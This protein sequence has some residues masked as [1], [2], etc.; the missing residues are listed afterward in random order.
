MTKRH[1][2]IFAVGIAGLLIAKVLL[3]MV[4]SPM[5]VKRQELA[6][7]LAEVPSHALLADDEATDFELM[8]KDLRDAPA[9]WTE[10]VPPPPPAPPPPPPKPQAP[11]LAE[12][13][14]AIE[15]GRGQIGTT[16]IKIT[17]PD[18]PRGTWL[19]LG[20]HIGGCTLESFTREEAIFSFFWEEGDETLH[21][22]LPR[23]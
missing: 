8:V 1:A 3:N 18:S 23:K 14:S 5:D 7:A 17:T 20:E 9:L 11:D 6:D 2:S 15:V 10:L 16:K 13:L 12:M 4:V 19:Q 22:T 21:I